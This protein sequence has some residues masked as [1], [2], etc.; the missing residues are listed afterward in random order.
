MATFDVNNLDGLK[1]K[2]LRDQRIKVN[3]IF[4][5]KEL[6]DEIGKIV[7]DDI[8]KTNF[9]TPAS[10]TKAWR[11]YY[12]NFNLTDPA[13]SRNK[14]NITFTGELLKD[15]LKNVK[16]IT[17]KRQFV[18][19][20]SNKK[21]KPYKGQSGTIGKSVPFKTIQKGLQSLGYDYL[22]ISDR[23]LSKVQTAVQKKLLEI[24]T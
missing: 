10:S 5:D 14:I 21:H 12:E 8:K 24:L 17:T 15:L 9:G 4:R 22:E 1:K 11:R 13:Y 6:R 23:A 7:T 3:Q 20:H 16:A 18:V 19:A 2:I